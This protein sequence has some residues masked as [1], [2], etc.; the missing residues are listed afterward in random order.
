MRKMKRLIEKLSGLWVVGA[1]VIGMFYT[2]AYYFNMLEAKAGCVMLLAIGGLALI[3]VQGMWKERHPIDWTV[4]WFLTAV[5]LAN[6]VTP[7]KEEAFY[8]S[9]GWHVGTLLLLLLG[10]VYAG[11]RRVETVPIAWLYGV[12]VFVSLEFAWVVANGFY[13]DIFGYHNHLAK[14]DYGRYVGSIGNTNW[15]V[16]F[17]ALVLPFFYYGAIY[18]EKR[19]QRGICALGVWLGGMSAI[20]IHC[21]GIF[22]VLY[23][24][25]IGSAFYGLQN[26]KLLL[27]WRMDGLLCVSVGCVWLLSRWIPMVPSDGLARIALRPEI[28]GS[29][30]LVCTLLYGVTKWRTDKK[31]RKVAWVLLGSSLVVVLVGIIY[32]AG[33]FDNHWGTNRGYIWKKALAI[34]K[35]FSPVQKIFGGGANCFGKYYQA[36]TGSDWVRNAHNEL[37]EY[38]V[39][40]GGFG[41]CAYL[42][43]FISAMREKTQEQPFLIAG[44]LAL[45]AYFVQGC[46]NNPQA[47]NAFILVMVFA[48]YRRTAEN[49]LK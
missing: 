37:L 42:A 48:I 33:Q 43:V 38:L 19:W 9:Y 18:G 17:L 8:G 46:V 44:K 26:G 5:V 39:C 31:R 34:Y 21:D 32:V 25:I 35:E 12:A 2:E 4:L 3:V 20:T 27:V 29:G 11:L 41:V 15:Y 14:E 23:V 6:L 47:Y 24:L 45:L 49:V 7:Y 16:G 1:F 30:L 10:G 22:L 28:W 13:L 36:Q 40:T